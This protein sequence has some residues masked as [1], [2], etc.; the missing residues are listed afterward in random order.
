MSADRI[1][2]LKLIADTSAATKGMKDAQKGM[3][4]S[5]GGISRGLK[6]FGGAM[7]AAFAVDQV[8]DFGKA[9]ID[10]ASDVQESTSK[11]DALVGKHAGIAEAFA[12]DAWKLGLSRQEAIGATADFA[13][14]F[15]TLGLGKKEAANASVEFTQLAIDMASFSNTSVDEAI[16]ALG[17]GL[18]GESEPLRKY[19]VLLDDATLRSYA[20]RHGIIDVNRQL[21]PQEKAMAAMGVI[22]RQTKKAQ[23][24]AARTADQ[25]A[26][27]VKRLTAFMDNATLAIG[28]A[29]LPAVDEL[30]G[31]LDKIVIPAL[32]EGFNSPELKEFATFAES[33][34]TP[35]LDDLS[36]A[37]RAM[38]LLWEGLQPILSQTLTFIQPLID[39][40]S[41]TVEG[42]L[43]FVLDAVTGVLT[44]LG[45]LLKGD[46]SGALAAASEAVNGM[47]E[48]VQK[49]VGGIGTF[50]D[51]IAGGVLTSAQAIG[52][53][54]YDGIVNGIDTIAAEVR[55]VVNKII[56]ALNS[57]NNFTWERQGFEVNSVFG[58]AF[59]GVDS[60]SI[61]LW[62]DIAPLAKGG[63]VMPRPGGTLA[64]I[65]EAGQAEAVIPLDR[66]GDMGG[67]STYV[68]N[69]N[70][71]ATADRVAIGKEIVEAIRQYERRS[72][73]VWR[74]A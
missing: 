37:V 62:P 53:N 44:T 51:G 28:E 39:L 20:L 6:M 5:M 10:M 34:L 69:V 59:V 19:G 70:V 74:T 30:V 68:I 66:L 65:G 29:L 16:T 31:A 55:G 47:W 54:I 27:S 7:V 60:G 57:I 12:K 50:L 56:G 42:G 41:S 49:I 26:G 2:A 33:K 11:L 22:M 15:N 43:G 14:L 46:F 1:L 17:A 45:Q 21:T 4:K 71:A 9:A 3:N 63:I 40:L 58:N 64:Q 24:D 52:T 13:H 36:E 32:S 23:G 67:G 38:G 8:L 18:R 35:I 61:Q 25:H 72:G 73:K 48:N